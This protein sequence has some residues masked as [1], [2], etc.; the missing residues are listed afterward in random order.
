MKEL[1]REIRVLIVDDEPLARRGIAV[2]LRDQIGIIVVGECENGED[3]L[4]AILSLKPDLVFLD[5]QMQDINGIDVLRS[6][7]SEEMPCVIFVTAYDGYAISAFELHALDYVLK[8]IDD[9]RFAAALSHARQHVTLRQQQKFHIRLDKLLRSHSQQE[10]IGPVDRFAIREGNRITFVRTEEIDWIEAVGDYVG[11]HV[12]RRTHL[13]R[14]TIHALEAVLDRRE[15]LRIH[16]STI[17]RLDRGVQ[18]QTLPNRE[19]T[20][21]LNDGTSLRVSRSHSKTLR[22]LF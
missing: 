11:L 7:S 1:H 20:L 21:T 13:L 8:P 18:V 12:G 5:I 9:E 6:L 4:T 16:R 22:D 14:E 2:R 15:F 17:V 3:A 19:C 10:G